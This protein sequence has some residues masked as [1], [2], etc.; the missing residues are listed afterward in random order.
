MS[1]RPPIFL[2]DENFLE[3]PSH[4]V[5]QFIVFAELQT[6]SFDSISR[7]RSSRKDVFLKGTVHVFFPFSQPQKKTCFCLPKSCNSQK[8]FD[9]RILLTQIAMGSGFGE[10]W[11]FRSGGFVKGREC[12]GHD[13]VFHFMV[14]GLSGIIFLGGGRWMMN[15]DLISTRSG[16]HI[17]FFFKKEGLNQGRSS[18]AIG[19]ANM[20]SLMPAIPGLIRQESRNPLQRCRSCRMNEWAC[21][22]FCSIYAKLR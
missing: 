22:L 3:N 18:P 7:P 11:C 15:D 8:S 5:A 17:L 16:N 20:R 13:E 9:L 21:C 14:H 19:P 4:D 10:G 12:P 1:D 6:F 2:F